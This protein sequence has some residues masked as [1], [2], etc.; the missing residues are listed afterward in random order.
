MK[1]SPRLMN[2]IKANYKV[3]LIQKMFRHLSI[4]WAL[5]L[6][7]RKIYYIKINFLKQLI[8]TFKSKSIF[9]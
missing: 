7:M 5:S 2:K 3:M 1:G 9:S 8:I 4:S 6:I